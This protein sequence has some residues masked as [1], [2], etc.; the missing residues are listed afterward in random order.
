[1]VGSTSGVATRLKMLHPQL[2]S[3]HCI[4]HR[5]A[6]GTSQAAAVVPY[7]L[8]FEE[9]VISIF[10]FYHYSATRQSGLSKFLV[11]LYLAT[12]SEDQIRA[13]SVFLY[14]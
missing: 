8:R 5:L 12:C 7:L 4:N 3:I 6:L 2:L 13:A 10:K 1:M 11:N 14:F 9:I